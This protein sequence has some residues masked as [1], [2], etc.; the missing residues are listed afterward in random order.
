[1]LYYYGDSLT[2]YTIPDTRKSEMYVFHCCTLV[3]LVITM[4]TNNCHMRLR[5]GQSITFTH[6]ERTLDLCIIL[7]MEM[8]S[9]IQ[10][11]VQVITLD[12]VQKSMFCILLYFDYG[13]EIIS[14]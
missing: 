14:Y 3:D 4:Q 10:I 2:F 13:N 12:I 8:K 9:Y 1:M 6:I 5:N 7:I 11:I